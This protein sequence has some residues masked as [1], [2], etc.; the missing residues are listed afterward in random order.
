MSGRWNSAVASV[1]ARCGGDPQRI[2]R[3]HAD[4]EGTLWLDADVGRWF[5][6][7]SGGC[8]EL[9]PEE[10]RRLPLAALLPRL[11]RTGSIEV[12]SWRPGRRLVLR[13]DRDGGSLVVKGYRRGR[14]GPAA[15][16]HRFGAAVL[17]ASAED[18]GVRAP[19]LLLHDES[20]ESL[21]F[22]L[23]DAEALTLADVGGTRFHALGR[24]VRV[25][26][27]A[28][29]DEQLGLHDAAAE[30]A[31]LQRCALRLRRVDLPPDEAWDSL[32]RRLESERDDDVR[33][34]PCPVH[35]DLHDGQVL[36]AA[37]GLVLLDF[38]L[39]AAG[40]S[41]TDVAN[42]LAHLKLRQLQDRAHATPRAVADHGRALL[43]GFGRSDEPGFARRLRWWQAATFL[44]LA[45]V[46]GLRPRD[47][48]LCGTL[49]SLAGRCLDDRAR[50]Y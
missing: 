36:V 43:E 16:R 8:R 26:Q 42:L 21:H 30:L 45:L 15:R 19:E 11:R 7:E 37:D 44:R 23:E 31:V 20:T 39:L 34:A 24:A 5:V 48:G 41:A 40:D 13:L 27:E 47:R 6:S 17:Q 25:L 29:P 4:D 10:D 46:H 14:S 38:D 35:R 28:L 18:C 2:G 9:V 12:L 49:A 3:V 50:G 32:A 1:A 33:T 22:K